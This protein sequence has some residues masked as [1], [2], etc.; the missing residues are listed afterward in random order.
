MTSEPPP[1]SDPFIPPEAGWLRRNFMRYPWHFATVIGLVTITAMR[2]CTRHVP[3]PPPVIAALPAFEL[4]DQDGQPFSRETMRGKVWVAGL[5]FTTCPS[6]CPKISR[7][8]LDLQQR[9]ARAGV[10]VHL[11]SF[12]VDPERDTPEVLKKYAGHLEADE[13]RWRFV[14]GPREAVEALVIGGFGS[15]MDRTAG[16]GGM[17]DIAHSTR[18]ILIDADGNIRGH[19]STDDELGLDEVYHRA[20]HVLREMRERQ[21]GCGRP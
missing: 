7:A 17:I 13:S 11:V 20:Q 16:P 19:Y 12:S 3:D 18:L 9:W 1:P 5:I 21:A 14:T 10:D 8:M 2:P 15:A 4:V 6:S